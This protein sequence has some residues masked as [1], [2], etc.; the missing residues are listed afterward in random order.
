MGHTIVGM[1]LFSAL[2]P[3][4]LLLMDHSDLLLLLLHHLEVYTQAWPS[5][6]A[7]Q[8]D[9]GQV[10]TVAYLDHEAI[11][12]VKKD[13]INVNPAFLHHRPHVS[14]PHLL[15]LLLHRAHALTLERNMI[16]LWVDFSLLWNVIWIL[17]LQQMYSDPV[18]E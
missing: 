5:P 1:V 12:V 13:L 10:V 7:R 14:N 8:R 17:C 2:H 9:D 16:I 3:T 11:R 4:I 15:Q 18:A 6:L